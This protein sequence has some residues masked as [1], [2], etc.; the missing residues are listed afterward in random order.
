[1]E[2]KVKKPFYKRWWFIAIVAFFILG[3]IGNMLGDSEEPAQPVGT[4]QGNNVEPQGEQKNEEETI[5][6][7][8]EQLYSEYKENEVAADQKYKG[9]MLEV[10]GT[11]NNIGKDIVDN[12]Y[13]TLDTGELIASVQCY[14]KKSEEETVAGLK[15]GQ[16]VT[17]VGKGD[18]FL[19]NAQVKDCK[20]K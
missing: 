8:A 19:L 17:V 11:I 7:T 2:K 18:G 14:F 13:I 3:T 15:K 4:L 5:K 6:V 12:M 20:I 1:M 9:K 10:S 16:E